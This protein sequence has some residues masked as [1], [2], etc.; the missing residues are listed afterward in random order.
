MW[1]DNG[2]SFSYCLFLHMFGNLTKG[3]KV[4]LI[5][6]AGIHIS[7]TLNVLS[8]SPPRISWPPL[9]P[10]LQLHRSLTISISY[11]GSYF[12]IADRTIFWTW[13]I[14]LLKFYPSLHVQLKFHVLQE[15]FLESY[16]Q[17]FISFPYTH[18]SVSIHKSSYYMQTV[19]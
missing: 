4:L 1:W 13:N 10:M 8:D 17:K 15:S 18:H 19:S 11:A 3:F 14:S 7:E 9:H 12:H 6:L 16:S 2:G 5:L